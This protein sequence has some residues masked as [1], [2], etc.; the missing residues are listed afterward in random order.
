L[1]RAMRLVRLVKIQQ[2]LKLGELAEHVEDNLGM[3][4]SV[5]KLLKPLIVMGAAAHA[6]TCFFFSGFPPKASIQKAT[7][8]I[9]N[10]D[11]LGFCYDDYSRI[12]R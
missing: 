9:F 12:W 11:V 8:T 6:L 1:F 5:L 2:K 4:P 7:H 10:N 3:N